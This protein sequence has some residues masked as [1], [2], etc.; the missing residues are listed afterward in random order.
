MSNYCPLQ[1]KQLKQVEME[2]LAQ[3]QKLLENNKLA[4]QRH[5]LSIK[6][7]LAQKPVR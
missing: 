1:Q 6:L 4:A 3:K 2:L 7:L 5:L